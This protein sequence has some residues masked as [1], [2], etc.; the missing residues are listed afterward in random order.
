MLMAKTKSGE[1]SHV[2]ASPRSTNCSSRASSRAF[3]SVPV[4]TT[5]TRAGVTQN[6][7]ESD[8][9]IVALAGR[10]SRAVA[11]TPES[12]EYPWLNR[13][14]MMQFREAEA[15]VLRH[16][17]KRTGGSL[18]D[19]RIL[20]IGCGAGGWIHEL[21]HWGAEPE[22]IYG[23]DALAHRLEEARRKVPPGVNLSLVNAAKLD[24]ADNFFDLVLMFHSVSMMAEEQMRE[25]VASEALR[26]LKPGGAV[27]W[28]DFR[29]Q[30]PTM[31]GLERRISKRD[32]RRWFPGCRFHLESILAFPPISRRLARIW[33][34]LWYL[35][36]I[37]PPLRV[38]YVGSIIKSE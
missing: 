9:D 14:Y 30:R 28:Y 19:R 31:R 21:I 10:I 13:G 3:E 25:S 36:K 11:K 2:H 27:L 15:A 7:L 5:D 12:Y 35:L 34:P 4:H 20:D 22:L 8:Q 37:I 26:V 24:F 29:Y 6:H 1:L 23:V 33:L 32:L 18:R 17:S 38:C 16:I